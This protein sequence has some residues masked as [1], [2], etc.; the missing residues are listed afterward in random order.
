ME[1]DTSGVQ[2]IVPPDRP[3]H[4]S[5]YPNRSLSSMPLRADMTAGPEDCNKSSERMLHSDSYFIFLQSN[6]VD[7]IQFVEPDKISGYNLTAVEMQAPDFTLAAGQYKI[8][9]MPA[10]KQPFN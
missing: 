4:G 2:N 5:Q 10:D 6:I 3:S 8:N 9:A 1:I 7:F